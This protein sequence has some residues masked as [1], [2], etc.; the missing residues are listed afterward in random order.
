MENYYILGEMHLDKIPPTK[1]KSFRRKDG[2]EGLAVKFKMY[3]LKYPDKMGNTHTMQIYRSQ[4]DREAGEEV[5]FFG[6]CKI[7]RLFGD[8]APAV[9]DEPAF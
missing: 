4:S 3:R 6:K 9:N 7:C 2:S 8:N 5:I 1:V